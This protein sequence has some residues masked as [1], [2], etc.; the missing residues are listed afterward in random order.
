MTASSGNVSSGLPVNVMQ[1]K[2]R[3][4]VPK[5]TGDLYKGQVSISPAF[6][7]QIFCTKVFAAAFLY[8]QFGFVI[9]W[10]KNIGTKDASK[11]LVKLTTDVN[12]TNILQAY[13]L[14]KA[15]YWS[16]YLLIV[17]T[18]NFLAKINWCKSCS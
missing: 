18:V 7:K 15:V 2:T 5:L 17:C 13:F 4:V 10:Q 8:L 6:Y 1:Q 12:F 3:S 14:Y 9:F 16:F 11:M